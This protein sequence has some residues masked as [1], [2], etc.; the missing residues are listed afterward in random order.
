MPDA[1]PVGVP[2]QTTHSSQVKLRTER[3]S[4]PPLLLRTPWPLREDAP[5]LP[6]G[7]KLEGDQDARHPN[8]VQ[9]DARDAAHLGIEGCVVVPEEAD[10]RSY[11]SNEI[12]EPSASLTN[13]APR[14]CR[15]KRTPA[16]ASCTSSTSTGPAAISVSMS[17]RV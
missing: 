15:T 8:L 7:S 14:R 12:I 9:A 3:C 17:S 1:T 4:A 2:L 13:P 10:P 5:A 16:G 6:L 11:T